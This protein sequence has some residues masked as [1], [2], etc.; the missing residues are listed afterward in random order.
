MV[1]HAIGKRPY[2]GSLLTVVQ[3]RWKLKGV[4]HLLTME[5]EVLLFKFSCAE[6]FEAVWNSGPYFR[7]ERSFIF[8]KGMLDFKLIKEHF[9]EIRLWVK[10]LNFPLCCSNESV[11]YKV[12]KKLASR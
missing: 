1:S 10:F 6:Y 12:E 3:K 8:K 9:I 7:N 5:N 2:Y 11:L 4:L